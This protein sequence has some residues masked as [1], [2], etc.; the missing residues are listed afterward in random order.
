MQI[1]QLL[2]SRALRNPSGKPCK[3][4]K[5]RYKECM[6]YGTTG[7]EILMMVSEPRTRLGDESVQGRGS[8]AVQGKGK[9]AQRPRSTNLQRVFPQNDT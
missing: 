5:M 2:S 7:K 6:C 8:R 1:R 3:Q 4:S 9:I